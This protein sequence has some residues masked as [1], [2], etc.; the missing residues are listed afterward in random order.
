M[1]LHITRK[2]RNLLII[3][4]LFAI[5]I[6]IF[7][8][9]FA[10]KDIKANYFSNNMKEVR[11]AYKENPQALD[12]FNE[13]GLTPLMF[14]INENNLQ[15]AKFLL[16]QKADPNAR[17]DDGVTALYFAIVNRNTK[18]V[19][20]LAKNGADINQ[21]VQ[22]VGSSS[23]FVYVHTPLTLAISIHDLSM[24]RTL[25][26]NGA[27][28]NFGGEII[29]ADGAPVLENNTPLIAAVS[30]K[31]VDM[32]RL[33]IK[34]GANI[35]ATARD[36][37][38]GE[39]A[40]L[41][42][43]LTVAI[44]HGDIE[45]VELLVENGADTNLD[46]IVDN[47]L[48]D[49]ISM[50]PVAIAIKY[51]QLEILKYLVEKGAS[52]K[53]AGTYALAFSNDFEILKYLSEV[54]SDDSTKQLK[55]M[56]FVRAAHVI[57]MAEIAERFVDSKK[58]IEKIAGTNLMAAIDVFAY[59]SMLSEKKRGSFFETSKTSFDDIEKA[60]K[61]VI[62]ELD[63]RNQL[64]RPTTKETIEAL[65][66]YYAKSLATNKAAFDMISFDNPLKFMIVI[67]EIE[68][69]ESL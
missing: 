6:F 13:K 56:V 27:D 46:T 17:T 40:D 25:I 66:Q 69:N 42:T 1:K 21:P 32:I 57:R 54:T 41:S 31:N 5:S 45:I 37:S 53:G 20:L 15:A 52:L 8:A 3:I 39:P 7:F 22:T 11:M 47:A 4:S 26:E 18:T 64:Y 44:Q 59:L 62:S 14:A 55:H 48:P 36:Y 12:I 34:S 9:A 29:R 33:L 67:E 58:D 43:P 51:K 24:A 2:M 30:L 60:F 16:A 63:Y 68:S 61:Y 35:N 23:G 19:E 10:S 28:V 65:C 50:T 49:W 38:M